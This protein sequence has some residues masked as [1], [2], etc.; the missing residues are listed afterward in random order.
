MDWLLKQMRHCV[1][2]V[3]ELFN[4]VQCLK[5]LVNDNLESAF[6]KWLEASGDEMIRARV[7]NYIALGFQFALNDAGY[8]VA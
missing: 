6:T 1:D 8:F 7:N 4:E 3:K 5:S 2:K